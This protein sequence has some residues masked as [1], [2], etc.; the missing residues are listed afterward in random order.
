ML[1]CFALYHHAVFILWCM[2]VYKIVRS[3]SLCVEYFSCPANYS[4]RLSHSAGYG[5][6]KDYAGFRYDGITLAELMRERI[7]D[8]SGNDD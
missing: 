8:D 3:F 5:K 1:F 6:N 4:I 7:S 2:F